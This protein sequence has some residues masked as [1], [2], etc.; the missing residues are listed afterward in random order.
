MFPEKYF[1]FCSEAY[2]VVQS[3]ELEV[4]LR[5]GNHRVRIDVL[6]ELN[7]EKY[8]TKHYIFETIPVSPLGQENKDYNFVQ[9]W[10]HYDLPWTAGDT[11]DDVLASAASFLQ[12]RAT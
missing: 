5:T 2:R 1:S 8:T 12:E 6:Q 11:A 7:S 10:V 3:V 9:T 4:S